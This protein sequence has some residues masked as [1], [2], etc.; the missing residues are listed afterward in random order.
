MK[1]FISKV[2]DVIRIEMEERFGEMLDRM[3]MGRRQ[4]RYGESVR[5]NLI[6][7]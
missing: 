1:Y 2:W 5:E 7:I 6:T 4:D 3:E